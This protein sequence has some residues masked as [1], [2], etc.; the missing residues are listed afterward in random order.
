[1][2][3]DNNFTW[4]YTNFADVP[5]IN[6]KRRYFSVR[7]SVRIFKF[8]NRLYLYLILILD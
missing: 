5:K 3:M 8:E 2:Q 4:K 1:M 6:A 7:P